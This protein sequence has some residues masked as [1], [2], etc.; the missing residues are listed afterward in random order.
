MRYEDKK[1]LGGSTGLNGLKIRCS[2]KEDGSK[3]EDKWL[4]VSEGYNGKWKPSLAF[5]NMGVCGANVR[6]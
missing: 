2:V 1:I 6:F 4:T 3:I 5:Q